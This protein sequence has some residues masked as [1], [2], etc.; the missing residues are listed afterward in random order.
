[1]ESKRRQ[2]QPIRREVYREADRD[3]SPRF[4]ERSEDCLTCLAHHFATL[5][6][7]VRSA[8]LASSASRGASNVMPWSGCVIHLTAL[9]TDFRMFL[10][11]S[12]QL[13][14]SRF[15]QEHLRRHSCRAW[16]SP[17]SAQVP[18]VTS[19]KLT[20]GC[21]QQVLSGVDVPVMGFLPD[22]R[23]APRSLGRPAE[24]EGRAA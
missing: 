13:P 2:D 18:E 20:H 10:T 5:T 6:H 24:Q 14:A 4:N 7:S 23:A 9:L 11:L 22:T 3:I 19:G 15:V 17:V 12:N 8:F 16:I 1:M 21:G